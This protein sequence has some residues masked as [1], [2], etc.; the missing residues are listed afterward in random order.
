MKGNGVHEFAF[1]RTMN[2]PHG[3]KKGKDGMKEEHAEEEEDAM[4]R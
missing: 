3:D 1:E 4:R 2:V